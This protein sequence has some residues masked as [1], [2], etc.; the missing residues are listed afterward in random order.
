MRTQKGFTLIELSI[1]LVII[2]LL[3]GGVLYGGD[4]IK[5][6]EIRATISQM[7]SFDTAAMT[8]RLKYNGM[9]GDLAGAATR[10]GFSATGQGT[11]T[12]D[13]LINRVNDETAADEIDG[14]AALFFRHLFQA[15]MIGNNITITDGTIGNVDSL[16]A[17]LPP[18]KMGRSNYIAVMNVSG[19]NQ[20][21][22]FGTTG[23]TNGVATFV[24]KLTPLDAYAFDNKLDDGE[25]TTGTVIA[26]TD[27]VTAN[28]DESGGGAAAGECVNSTAYYTAASA[29][30]SVDGCMI[31]RRPSF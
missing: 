13:G 4:L 20:M 2:G 5:A 22:L 29:T 17:T 15:N 27:F 23:I 19:T 30:A 18:A 31:R 25:A 21:F 12:A 11:A 6:A 26:V 10:F 28:A 8:F 16:T 3:V 14:E 24:D 1:V 9:P 7:S